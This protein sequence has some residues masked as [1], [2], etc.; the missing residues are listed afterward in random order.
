MDSITG[1]TTTYYY[2]LIDRIGKYKEAGPSGY[3]H[4]V[5]YNYDARNNISALV[6]TV[7]DEKYTTDYTFDDQNRLT[8]TTTYG[9]DGTQFC[10]LE[11]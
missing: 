9:T 4:S 3:K 6:E 2:D 10:D 1:R 5:S 7:G 11:W 8:G